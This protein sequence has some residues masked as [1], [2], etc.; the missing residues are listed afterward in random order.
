[1]SSLWGES[2]MIG[3]TLQNT[4]L[5]NAMPRSAGDTAFTVLQFWFG[6]LGSVTGAP[7]TE[8][9]NAGRKI[10]WHALLSEQ[11][12]SGDK[13]HPCIVDL[14]G[15]DGHVSITNVTA[16]SPTGP[17][18][19]ETTP[20]EGITAFKWEF[21][22][23]D[24]RMLSPVSS[25][26]PR[27]V[28][29]ATATNEFELLLASDEQAKSLNDRMRALFDNKEYKMH[30]STSDGSDTDGCEKV[31]YSVRFK[32]EVDKSTGYKKELG[33]GAFGSVFSAIDLSTGLKIAVKEIDFV[34]DRAAAAV[35]KEV[36]L[37]KDLYHPN[38][39]RYLG[40]DMGLNTFLVF[41]EQVPHGVSLIDLVRDWEPLRSHPKILRNYSYQVLRGLNYLHDRANPIVHLDIKGDNVLVDRF[42]GVVK[43]T[44]FGVSHQLKSLYS[45]PAAA[46]PAAQP[47][48]GGSDAFDAA[49]FSYSGSEMDD[50]G[51]MSS[52]MVGTPRFQSPEIIQQFVSSLAPPADIWSFGCL[53]VEIASGEIPYADYDVNGAVCL[54]VVLHRKHPDIPPDLDPAAVNF[55]EHCF[56]YEPGERHGARF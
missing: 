30:R 21:V 32:Y 54:L 25:V 45:V 28:V 11:Q 40:S 14:T 17:L 50:D 2:W 39:V 52:T 1:M 3:T 24:I 55:I 19:S 38:I 51:S 16:D 7:P 35:Q 48:T 44:D 12:L 8:T 23:T 22:N 36:N 41:Q 29:V 34:D 47:E 5:I 26:A 33:R 13:Y 37:Q 27:K 31:D 9:A 4:G 46:Q 6:Y 42:N 53:M 15:E 49:S 10:S 56:K 43:L 20:M 18:D